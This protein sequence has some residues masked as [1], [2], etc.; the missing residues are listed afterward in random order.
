M[1][2]HRVHSY[3]ER[4]GLIN[5]GIYKR[6]KPLPSRFTSDF[7]L[8]NF[9]WSVGPKCTLFL[10]SWYWNTS[11]GLRR[12]CSLEFLIWLP[13]FSFLA[14]ILHFFPQP[15]AELS[16]KFEDVIFIDISVI[17]RHN[18]S[19][20]CPVFELLWSK[21]CFAMNISDFLLFVCN[22]WNLK[23]PN[24]SCSYSQWS[25]WEINS[26]FIVQEQYIFLSS[27]KLCI[28]FLFYFFYRIL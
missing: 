7:K 13:K 14:K 25:G 4:H 18:T 3:L 17:H 9:L 16:E 5:F 23:L 11:K 8:S 19:A 12:A 27:M 28:A 1:L 24:L 15:K 2:V 10:A 22:T 26:N 21:K 6:V 20:A